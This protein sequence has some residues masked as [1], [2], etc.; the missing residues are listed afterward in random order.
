[1]KNL[2]DLKSFQSKKKTSA[3]KGG[4]NRIDESLV[5]RVDD[6]FVVRTD[7]IIP[8]SLANAY[9]KKVKDESGKPMD[10]YSPQ[11]VADKLAAFLTTSYINIENFPTSIIL[12]SDFTKGAQ[13]QPQAQ[14]PPQGQAPVQETQPE[15][16]VETPQGQ[17]QATAQEIPAQEGGG[18]GQEIQGAATQAPQVPQGGQ[19]QTP[20]QTV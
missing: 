1:M 9:L 3:L 10:M 19:T 2:I 12:G 11:E 20:T 5:T 8:V 4:T 6:N 13:I 17:A 16:Q 18:Q 14:M 15:A 7:V